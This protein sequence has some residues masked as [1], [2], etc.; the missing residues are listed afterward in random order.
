MLR[1]KKVRYSSRGG[2]T[3]EWH[4]PFSVRLSVNH[5]QALLMQLLAGISDDKFMKEFDADERQVLR[6]YE[7]LKL[8][9]LAEQIDTVNQISNIQTI[10]SKI[11]EHIDFWLECVYESSVY[12][13]KYL[14]WSEPGPEEL[15]NQK[16]R[17]MLKQGHIHVRQAEYLIATV[18]LPSAK[19]IERLE[20][21][22]GPLDRKTGK[23]T[24]GW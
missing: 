5:A 2:Y 10:E 14:G 19:M 11:R 13:K 16:F 22:L 6:R 23:F 4:E 7:E 20:E 15:V 1:P 17:S 8:A 18:G 3:V 24:R 21:R 9:A 12:Q